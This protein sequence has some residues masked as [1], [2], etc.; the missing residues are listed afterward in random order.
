MNRKTAS[1][2]LLLL[3]ASTV[4]LS[5]IDAPTLPQPPS[6]LARNIGKAL[7]ALCCVNA[8]GRTLPMVIEIKCKEKC[9]LKKT[10]MGCQFKR[11]LLICSQAN[12]MYILYELYGTENTSNEDFGEKTTKIPVSADKS[13]NKPV[14]KKN[15]LK[16]VLNGFYGCFHMGSVYAWIKCIGH[17][18]T[19]LNEHIKSKN[20]DGM[21]KEYLNIGHHAV[22]IPAHLYRAYMHFKEAIK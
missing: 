3:S 2:M 20:A 5:A 8:A 17:H 12:L 21:A 11:F 9:T 6:K 15:L 7:I 10:C 22:A 1:L 19:K 4:P 14:E 18:K 16:S 13:A